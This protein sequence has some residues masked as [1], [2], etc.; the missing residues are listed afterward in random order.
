[1]MKFIGKNVDDVEWKVNDDKKICPWIIKWWWMNFDPLW[2]KNL[3]YEQTTI[4]PN[5]PHSGVH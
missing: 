2:T 5:W 4:E 1:M 3:I